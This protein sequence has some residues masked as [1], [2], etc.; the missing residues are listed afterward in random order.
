[1][2]ERGNHDLPRPVV[3]KMRWP[4]P[5][6][7]IVP[8]L[9]AALAGYYFYGRAQERGE[10][11]VVL[12]ED[13]S[14]LKPGE[15][16][17]EYRGV[18]VG[19]VNRMW[20][21]DDRS[22]VYVEIRIQKPVEDIA[23]EGAKFWVERPDFSGGNFSG[24][25]TFFSGPFVQVIPGDGAPTTQ[26]TGL[27]SAPITTEKNSLHIVLHGAQVPHLQVD[28]PVYFRGMVVGEVESVKLGP[29]ATQVDVH[30]V[31]HA[32][33]STLVRTNSQFWN[34]SGADLK[35]GI[36][37][38]IS[39]KLESLRSL[40]SGGIVFASPDKDMGPPA[41][42]GAEFDLHDEAKKDWQAWS[43]RIELPS[44]NPDKP[45]GKMEKPQ[46]AVESLVK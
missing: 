8:I 41:N 12:F 13:A 14:G 36:F 7:W 32:R 9:A 40:I 29:D 23:K 22:Q 46:S 33:Y 6:I 17:V 45:Q 24:F 21:T 44:D 1:M 10:K 5:W 35:G 28:S 3:K 16:P 4:F 30:V 11:I 19:Q 43:P 37:T 31:I 34:V 18:Q 25:S 20:L 42:P 38:G 26:F 2:S 27:N 15:T 39:F